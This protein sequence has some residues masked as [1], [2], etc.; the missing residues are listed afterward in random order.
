MRVL[1]AHARK[2][3]GLIASAYQEESQQLGAEFRAFPSF[4]GHDFNTLNDLFP[5][6]IQ[7]RLDPKKLR[8]YFKQ[9]FWYSIKAQYIALCEAIREFSP[10]VILCD[11]FFLGV[12]SMLVGPCTDRPMIIHWE[13]N[14]LPSSRSD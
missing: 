4:I 13:V 9:V 6:R 1:T 10:E 14:I 8:V 2:V 12:L 11:S 5:Q 7:L 3:L